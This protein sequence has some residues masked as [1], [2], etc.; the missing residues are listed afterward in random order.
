MRDRGCRYICEFTGELWSMKKA[1]RLNQPKHLPTC[2]GQTSRPLPASGW[3]EGI[4][5]AGTTCSNQQECPNLKSAAPASRIVGTQAHLRASLFQPLI[6]YRFGE[7]F[8]FEC[9]KID[10]APVRTVEALCEITST[11]RALAKENQLTFLFEPTRICVC[12]E[13]R[14]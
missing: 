3:R 13:V 9:S 11:A 8:D 14:L 10:C 12:P 7:A 1:G 6:I 4:Y 5:F 2:Y